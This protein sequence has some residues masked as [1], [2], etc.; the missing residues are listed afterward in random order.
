MSTIMPE[1]ELLRRAVKWI[2]EQSGGQDATPSPRIIDEA[3]VRF[4]LGPLDQEA[5]AR[6]FRQRPAQG[7]GPA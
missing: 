2:C 6:F 5:L 1:G 4:N 7:D 3:A